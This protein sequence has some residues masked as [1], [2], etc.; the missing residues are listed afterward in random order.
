MGAVRIAAWQ[1]TATPTDDVPAA[2]AR[3]R[4]TARAAAAGGARVLVTPELYLTGYQRAPRRLRELAEPADGPLA[5]QVAK[6]AAECGIAL[7]YGWPEVSGGA[8]YNAVQLVDR[9]GSSLARYRKAHLFGDFDR[10]AFAPGAEGVVQA[11]LD[12]LTVGLLVCYDVEFPEAVRAHALAGTELLVVPTALA[13]P[14]EIVPRTLVVA[15]AFESQLFIAYAN[16]TGDETGAPYCG[17]SRVVGPDGTVLAE[18]GR[19][20]ALLF[21]D[22]DPAAVAEARAT[23]GYL[24]D[25]RP[26]LYRES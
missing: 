1:P 14:W 13:G 24:R 10:A 4:E 6:I 8:V 19:A 21:A 23:T 20:P 5:G 26:E 12:G 15:R 25:R 2:L 18:A 22:L 11:E 9:D 17:S 3:L 16:W 7:L